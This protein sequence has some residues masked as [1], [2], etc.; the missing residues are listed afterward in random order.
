MAT[1]NPCGVRNGLAM[2]HS[3]S[4]LIKQIGKELTC[5]DRKINH[6]CESKRVGSALSDIER[7]ASP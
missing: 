2:I 1:S 6:D 7:A 4:A 5:I 3:I